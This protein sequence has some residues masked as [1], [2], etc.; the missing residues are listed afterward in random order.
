[1]AKYQFIHA[2]SEAAPQ[3]HLIARTACP[4]LPDTALIAEMREQESVADARFGC[5]PFARITLLPEALWQDSLTEGLL[6]A[7]RP[8]MASPLARRWCWTSR[9][10]MTLCWLRCCVFCLTRRT[11]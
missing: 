7:L 2:L 8:L 5:A 3:S 4:L 9:R 1:M 11:G 6:T 10:S